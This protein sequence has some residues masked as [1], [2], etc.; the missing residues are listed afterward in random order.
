[1]PRESQAF[2]KN[3]WEICTKIPTPSPVLPSA[4]LPALCSNPELTLSQLAELCDPPVT[5]SC[6]NH[7][8]RKLLALSQAGD[9]G[10]A[11]PEA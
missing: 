11:R 4:S 6:L 7:R 8:L 1:M 9:G 3:L 10:Q 2:L 5:K